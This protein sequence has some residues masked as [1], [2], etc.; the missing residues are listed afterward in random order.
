MDDT[1]EE[2]KCAQINLQH[3]RV[4]TA[5]LMKYTHN[6]H[7]GAVYSPRE[8]GGISYTIQNIH[9]GGGTK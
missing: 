1:K 4:T 8:S 9:S 7:T 5:N 2:L 3:S 6:M